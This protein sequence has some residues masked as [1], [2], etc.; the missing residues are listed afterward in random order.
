MQDA[1][2]YRIMGS[3]AVPRAALREVARMKIMELIDAL[4]LEVICPPQN[5][6]APV[7]SACVSD[8][9]SHV[10]ATCGGNSLWITSQAHT[11]I[12]GV[13]SLLDMQAVVLAGC[14]LPTETVQCKARDSGVTLLHS[15]DSAFDLCGRIYALGIRG[16]A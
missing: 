10:M 12:I 8:L 11:N 2:K 15:C 9:L 1:P 3:K 14:A 7:E 5:P 4:N 13:A 16:K 6:E